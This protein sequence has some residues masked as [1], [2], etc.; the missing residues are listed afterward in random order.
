MTPNANMA[1][2][3]YVSMATIITRAED[4]HVPPLRH[5]TIAR[6]QPRMN[7]RLLMHRLPRLRPNLLTKV[8]ESMRERR[9]DASK[10]QPVRYR[11]RR[12]QE[13][14]RVV[15]VLL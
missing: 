11:K 1:T 3:M 13:E 2:G 8:E 10:R 14:R 7:I 6:H 4:D 12:R 15:V 5:L 9:G